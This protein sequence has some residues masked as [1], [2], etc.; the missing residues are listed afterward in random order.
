ME[1]GRS[2][3]RMV[4]GEEGGLCPGRGQRRLGEKKLTHIPHI[5]SNSSIKQVIEGLPAVAGQSVPMVLSREGAISEAQQ[6]HVGRRRS[7]T[8]QHVAGCRG[9][10]GL[11]A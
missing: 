9:R 1:E 11:Q 6:R 8:H 10:R 5:S 2:L 7:R 3:S 4:E